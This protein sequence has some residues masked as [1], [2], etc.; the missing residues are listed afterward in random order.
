MSNLRQLDELADVVLIDTGAG[1]GEMVLRVA[2][3]AQE[4]VLVTTPEP[5]AIM[6]AYAL[7]KS[8]SEKESAPPRVRLLVNRSSRPGD[9]EN[10]YKTLSAVARL[11]LDTDI[12]YLGSLPGDE[13][14]SRAVRLQQPFLISFPRS[15]VSKGV[16][17]LARCFL[18]GEPARR[19]GLRL[20]FKRLNGQKS[21]ETDTGIP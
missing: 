3:A 8:L 5:T 15:A 9:A 4:I 17:D 21:P 11:Y 7:I 13:A 19:N 10:T 18:D 6:D 12:E 16:E 1:V 2:G 20:F 14:V